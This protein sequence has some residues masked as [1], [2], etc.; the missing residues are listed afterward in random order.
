MNKY[1]M[2]LNQ[3]VPRR[4][5]FNLSRRKAESILEEIQ[6][7]EELGQEKILLHLIKMPVQTACSTKPVERYVFILNDGIMIRSRQD[8]RVYKT[9]MGY[10]RLFM[11]DNST[12][13]NNPDWPCDEIDQESVGEF[14]EISAV[15]TNSKTEQS[16]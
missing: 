15:P 8:W 9:P 6:E 4:K 12:D 2:K 5:F 1:Q 16:G 13:F 14:E 10:T 3:M 11:R 7:R